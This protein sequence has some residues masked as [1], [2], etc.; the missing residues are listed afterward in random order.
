MKYNVVS[1]I[2]FLRK[3]KLVD[4]GR[5]DGTVQTQKTVG[6]YWENSFE[7]GF[8]I[9]QQIQYLHLTCAV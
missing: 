8:K 6:V 5:P 3:L 4:G 7:M 1:K 9:C 2:D